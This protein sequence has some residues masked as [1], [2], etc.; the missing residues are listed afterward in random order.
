[1]HLPTAEDALASLTYS[2]DERV[3]AGLDLAFQQAV[4]TNDADMID[5][6]L[7]RD[8]WLV[9]GDG[10]VV[11]RE[12]LIDEALAGCVHYDAQDE[13]PGTQTV[14]VWGD[15]AVVTALLRIQGHRDGAAFARTLW[16]S[17]TY[18]RTDE[19]WKYVFAQA[20]LPLAES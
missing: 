9:L 17:D 8:F 2:H 20:S 16:F 13:L 1:M 14:R 15:T 5:R 6:L 18:V 10:T 12:A 4:K 3:V 19:G 7:H 11:S